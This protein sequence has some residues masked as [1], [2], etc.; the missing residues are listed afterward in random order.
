LIFFLSIIIGKGIY[1][2]QNILEFFNYSWFWFNFLPIIPLFCTGLLMN[3]STKNAMSR[4]KVVL[5]M[6]GVTITLILIDLIVQSLVEKYYD[7]IQMSILGGWL[8]ITPVSIIKAAGDK[9]YI[10]S[11]S[12]LDNKYI[13]ILISGTILGTCAF[14]FIYY[15]SIKRTLLK[16][17]FVLLFAG[18]FCSI[19]RSIF[20][21]NE[22]D[23][24]SIYGLL[25]FDLKDVWLYIGLYTFIQSMVQNWQFFRKTN[26]H[27]M[28]NYLR[29]EKNAFNNVIMVVK[30]YFQKMTNKMREYNHEKI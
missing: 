23:Y 22:Y 29:H 11:L 14:R 15:F 1:F 19:T 24:I 13:I 27:D 9:N 20:F 30:I 5:I 7:Y 12:V 8:K 26:K 2:K 10:S 3:Y 28:V 25:I 18:L 6:T 16:K 21:I 4:R 17:S